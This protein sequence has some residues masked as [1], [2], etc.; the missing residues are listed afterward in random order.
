MM[1]PIDLIEWLNMLSTKLTQFL[2]DF[3]DDI[4]SNDNS[5]AFRD[6][7]QIFANFKTKK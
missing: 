2:Y 4:T 3:F 1:T 5:D 7:E 6:L